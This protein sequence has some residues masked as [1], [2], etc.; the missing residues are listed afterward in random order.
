MV[1][2]STPWRSR[3]MAQLSAQGVGR[4]DLGDE[5]RAG[6]SC[7]GDVA[8][9]ETPHSVATELPA[10]GSGKQRVVGCSVTL[11]EPG[12]EHAACFAPEWSD[13]FL[14][15]FAVAADVGAGAELDCCAGEPGDLTDPETG[16]DREQ[17]QSVIASTDPSG[18][19]WCAEQCV[20]LVFGEVGDQGLA[21][22]FRR[23]GE[24][25][26]DQVG[27]LGVSVGGEVEQGADG[28]ESGVAG[29]HADTALVLEVVE[30]GSDHCC[31]EVFEGQLVGCAPGAGLNEAQ[32]QTIRVS[33]GGDGVLAGLALVD[34]SLGEE[35]FE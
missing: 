16:L 22:P 4:D 25:S 7:G 24:D 33:V 5:R 29:S 17:Y 12:A 14:A 6:K 28:G 11:G 27:V 26:L 15:S 23:D 20:G 34:Q 2:V 32:Q 30:E 10:S 18:K 9:D 35:R 3:F 19:V 21:G 8:L 13:P 31:V 1:A